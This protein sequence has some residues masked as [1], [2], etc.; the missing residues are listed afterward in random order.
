MFSQGTVLTWATFA[1][2]LGAVV[3]VALLVLRPLL[4]L[5]RRALDDASRLVALV[6]SGASLACA[7]AAW[8]LF[9]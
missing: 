9:D 5:T 7:L 6:A 8:R 3:I 4:G 2:L 1:P